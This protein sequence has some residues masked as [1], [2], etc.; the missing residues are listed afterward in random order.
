MIAQNPAS[1]LRR[2]FLLSESGGCSDACREGRWFAGALRDI[3]VV[4]RMGMWIADAD[5]DADADG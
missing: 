3:P 5:A 1:A 4:A 2:G